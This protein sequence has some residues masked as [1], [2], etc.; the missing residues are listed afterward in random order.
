MRAHR[1][2]RTLLIALV[3]STPW[4]AAHA[5]ELPGA[6]AYSRATDAL[7]AALGEPG[8]GPVPPASDPKVR[9][10]LASASMDAVFGHSAAQTAE[11][12]TTMQLC[13]KASQIEVT[14]IFADAA[15]LAAAHPNASPADQQNA[16]VTLANRNA[17]T[18]QDVI[19]PM[20]DFGARCTARAMPLLTDFFLK[21]P[22]D[23]RT[24]I[25][26]GGLAQAR[27]GLLNMMMGAIA[28]TQQQGL[29]E[30]NRRRVLA[31]AVAAAPAFVPV[32]V[33]ADRKKIVTAASAAHPLTA[34]DQASLTALI[35]AFSDDRCEGLCPIG[36]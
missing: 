27:N 23:Q 16:M 8:K 29:S 5:D 25:R 28:M 14:Y 10:A 31:A 19:V 17:E 6:T 30:T 33:L 7:I 12:R 20:I 11:L 26:L 18:Y 2:K 3:A 13:T 24:P 32:L 36:T 1:L 4:M 9:A 34:E 35:K 15:S 21:L 22:A